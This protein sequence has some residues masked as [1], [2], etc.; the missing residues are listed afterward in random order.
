M[1]MKHLESACKEEDSGLIPGLGRSPG[2]GNGNPLQDSCLENPTDRGAWKATVH[3]VAES[4]RTERPTLSLSWC[5]EEN[6]AE[7][8]HYFRLRFR[9]ASWGRWLWAET[10]TRQTRPQALEGD[11]LSKASQVVILVEQVWKSQRRCAQHRVLGPAVPCWPGPGLLPIDL[12][13]YSI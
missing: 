1:A 6:K 10:W 3:G 5:C 4:D 13:H 12:G 7:L 11:D 9:E 8:C 2:E